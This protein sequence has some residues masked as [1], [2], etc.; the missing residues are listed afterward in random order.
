LLRIKRLDPAW[1]VPDL[2]LED[3]VDLI[4]RGDRVIIRGPKIPSEVLLALK[5]LGIDFDRLDD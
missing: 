1:T 5:R 2:R 3:S 4:L